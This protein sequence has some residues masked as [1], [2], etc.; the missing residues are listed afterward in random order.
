MAGSWCLLVAMK[1]LLNIGPLWN[2]VSQS[3]LCSLL[4]YRREVCIIS[5]LMSLVMHALSAV[6]FLITFLSTV[7]LCCCC[8]L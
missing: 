2:E 4:V 8:R 6:Q 7:Q 1:I 3:A 5:L